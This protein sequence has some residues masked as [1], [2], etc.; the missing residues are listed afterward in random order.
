MKSRILSIFLLFF[1]VQASSCHNGRAYERA[2]VH[3]YDVVV[4]G[5]SNTWIGGDGCNQEKGWTRWFKESFSPTS[6][7][8]YARSGATWSNTR[9]TVHDEADSTD[10]L[11]DQNVIYN[12]VRRLQTSCRRG[13]QPVPD[14][15]LVAAGTNDAWFAQR[16]PGLLEKTTDE[17]F[18]DTASLSAMAPSAVLSLAGAVRQDCELLQAEFPDATI[19]LLTP[20][21]C[22]A[23]PAEAIE[24][25]GDIIEECAIR[26]QVGVVRQDHKGC[27]RRNE[28]LRQKH[29]TTDGIHT[30]VEGAKCMGAMLS[31]AVQDILARRGKA[32]TEAD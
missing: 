14:L 25:V 8:S 1:L 3:P 17:V 4:L 7:R 5:D 13:S 31:E 6:C 28:E 16:R 2:G 20:M 22:T 15:I 32:P 11:G 26:L 10:V 30:S 29:N 9:L 18:A 24:Q 21:Q 23:A 12:Q 19:V 27:V